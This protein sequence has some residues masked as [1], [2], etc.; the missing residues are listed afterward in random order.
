MSLTKI[1]SNLP[2][3][4]I[5]HSISAE[6]PV[7]LLER[8]VGN[9]DPVE[10]INSGKYLT[11][12]IAGFLASVGIDLTG[13]SKILDFGCG[14]GRV[15][16]WL[17][18]LNGPEVHGTD[19]DEEGIRW[20][21]DNL[22]SVKFHVNGELPP[23]GFNAGAFDFVFAISVFTHL[24][25]GHQ[26]QWLKEFKRIVKPG[27]VIL[28]TTVSH[29]HLIKREDVEV[30]GKENF[31]K[32]GFF[33]NRTDYWAGHFPSFYQDC[34]IS[35]SYMERYWCRDFEILGHFPG[36]MHNQD[37]TILRVKDT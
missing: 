23:I 1:F 17:S 19:Y 29:S 36:A 2:G 13:C 21:R 14:A 34:Y 37:V 11:E 7:V 31:L 28:L 3:N 12:R 8:T 33:F 35:Y 25:E 5:P 30:S 22:E 10:Y 24:D 16:R 26:L 6:P 18:L 27:G 15:I 4:H 20:C 32:Q 9:P